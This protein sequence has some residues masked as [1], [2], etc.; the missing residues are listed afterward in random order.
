MSRDIRAMTEEEL[1]CA[2]A[3]RIRIAVGGRPSTDDEFID[4]ALEA[5]RGVFGPVFEGADEGQR[6]DWIDMCERALRD[7][8]Q[9][10]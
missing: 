7:A 10:L 8:A 4:A 6:W 1:C 2:L 5:T 3:A 9:D